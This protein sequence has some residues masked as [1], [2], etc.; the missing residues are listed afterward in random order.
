MSAVVTAERFDAPVRHRG[1]APIA[2]R[3]PA[4]AA[5]AWRYL[6]QVALSLQ[7][8]SVLAADRALRNLAGYLA[9]A[10]VENFATVTR[11][12]IE[13]FKSWLSASGTDRGRAPARNTIR[14]RLGMVRS[15]FDRIIEWDWP[16]A[17]VRTPMFAI[18]VPVADDPL[19]RFLDDAR[20]ARLLA[21]AKSAP[22]LERLV[23]ELL[24]RTG[25]R[26]SELCDLEADAVTSIGGG[27]WLRIPVGKLHNDRYVPLLPM[28]VELID[29]HQATRPPAR[30][31]RLVERDDGQPF[32]R[33]TIHRWCLVRADPRL[34][35]NERI[36]G[37][38]QAER[39]RRG[40]AVLVFQ[41]SEGAL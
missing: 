38:I 17:P 14:Q 19:P 39:G 41:A 12:D 20:A 8:T 21:A 7:P 25:M 24:A 1:W 23:V 4:L 16:D 29:R 10:G 33:R 3:A 22:A 27:W 18:D 30:S 37:H 11:A 32:E 15:F 28:L 9:D 34:G 13:G 35:E 36:Q 31:G 5:T 26:A 2:E 40:R 6:D